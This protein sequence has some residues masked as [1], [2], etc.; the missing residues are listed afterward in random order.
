MS[1]EAIEA[2]AEVDGRGDLY[3]LGATAY[4]VLTGTPVFSGATAVAICS[5]HL[6]EVPE[7]PS[8]RLG[9][10]LPADL[11]RVLL[12]CLAKDPASRPRSAREL[13]TLLAACEDAALWSPD[14][15]AAW[16]TDFQVSGRKRPAEAPRPD[17]ITLQA[18]RPR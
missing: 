5:K 10:P 4:F 3:A 18:A 1:P 11:E 17:R 2:P 8:R 9:R 6:Q 15:V 14:R 13:E 12:R 16:W 7:P